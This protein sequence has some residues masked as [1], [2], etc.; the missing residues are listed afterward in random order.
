LNAIV[1]QI[2]VVEEI[3]ILFQK[4]CPEQKIASGVKLT[5]EDALFATLLDLSK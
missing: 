3:I 5:H 1:A 4:G 2:G